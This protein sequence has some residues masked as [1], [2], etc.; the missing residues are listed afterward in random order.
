MVME[1]W[2]V[3]ISVFLKFIVFKNYLVSSLKC[4]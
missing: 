2:C 4:D 3:A 1:L